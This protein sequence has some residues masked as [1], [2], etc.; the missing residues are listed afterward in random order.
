MKQLIYL[1][2]ASRAMTDVELEEIMAVSVRNNTKLGVT[3]LLIVKGRTFMQALEGEDAVVDA[4]YRRIEQDPRHYN[5]MHITAQ[6]IS[7]RQFPQW[8]MGFK[9]LD[10]LPP[11]ESQK[12]LDFDLVDVASLATQPD[13]VH[14]LF[15]VFVTSG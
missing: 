15:E 8:S 12:L 6:E 14:D 7:A 5:I 13:T 10:K 1:S 11:V 3:G 9:N 2:T 4:L